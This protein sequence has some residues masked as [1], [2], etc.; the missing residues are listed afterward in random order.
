MYVN[1]QRGHL[2]LLTM[3]VMAVVSI[4]ATTGLYISFNARTDSLLVKE[5]I[6]AYYIAD[7]GIELAL[8]KLQQ[9]V[10]W[11]KWVP[12]TTQWLITE[13]MLF[14]DKVKDGVI[15]SIKIK[16]L[17]KTEI[18]TEVKL[19]VEITSKG[20]YRQAQKTLVVTAEL[21]RVGPLTEVKITGWKELYPVFVSNT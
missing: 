18:E 1:N 13:P 20:V 3:V 12:G 17:T 2:L 11:S 8:T 21:I 9:D 5:K 7:G 4:S 10:D 15:E 6:Q 16:T 14:S 19:R